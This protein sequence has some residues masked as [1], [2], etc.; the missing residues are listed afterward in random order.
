MSWSLEQRGYLSISA[1][2]YGFL[3]IFLITASL[4]AYI[5]M[6][7][8]YGIKYNQ[9]GAISKGYQSVGKDDNDD[10]S[11]VEKPRFLERQAKAD[12]WLAGGK[13]QEEE[14]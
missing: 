3:F 7:S 12:H 10:K 2:L 14:V 6:Q 1:I 8:H 13:G 5:L 4:A 9:F 11:S